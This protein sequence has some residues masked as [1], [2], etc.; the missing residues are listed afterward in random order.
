MQAAQAEPVNAEKAPML[1]SAVLEQAKVVAPKPS[2]METNKETAILENGT[3][4]TATDE[5]RNA[6]GNALFGSGAIFIAKGYH[7]LA[8][9]VGDLVKK[10]S[11]L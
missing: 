8:Y 6:L 3:K 1:E 7:A 9:R 11:P 4:T 10:A 5:E 2:E